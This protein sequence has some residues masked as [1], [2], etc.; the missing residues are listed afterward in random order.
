MMT[1]SH[2]LSNGAPSRRFR[3]ADTAM[4]AIASRRASGHTMRRTMRRGWD[5]PGGMLAD[6][7]TPGLVSPVAGRFVCITVADSRG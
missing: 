6:T 1:P 3:H 7:V 4:P 5:A 2:A